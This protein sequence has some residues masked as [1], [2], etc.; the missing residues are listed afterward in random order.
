MPVPKKML[1]PNIQVFIVPMAL[2]V[3]LAFFSFIA[4]KFGFS[5]ISEQRGKLEEAKKNEI[6]LSQKESVL[7]QIQG[8]VPAYVDT[9]AMVVPEKNPSLMMITQLKN[10]SL[11]KGLTLGDIKVGSE[12]GKGTTLSGID[13]QFDVDGAMPNIIDFLTSTKTLAPVSSIERAKINQAAGVV[14]A[15]I[16][17]KVYFASFPERL[18]SLTDPVRELTADE[19]DILTKLSGFTFPATSVFTGQPPSFRENPFN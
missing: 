10:L 5:K 13:I 17:M 4:F 11:A 14:R 8:Q 7:R 12:V 19:K 1:P 18:P 9:V 6:V 3:A 15:E 2:L 16:E